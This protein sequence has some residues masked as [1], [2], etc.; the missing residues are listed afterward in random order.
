MTAH[1]P[2]MD[3]TLKV[4]RQAGP[5]TRGRFETYAAKGISTEMSFL[6]MLDVVNDR[7]ALDGKEPIAFDHDCREGICGCCGAVIN[8]KAHGS[9]KGT[10]LCQLQM[11]HYRN[12]Y[13][14][15][16]EPFRARAFPLI[17]DLAVDRTALD[18]IITTGGFISAK[19]GSAPDANAV[20]IPKR[21]ADL[22]MDA[23][24]CIG[25]GA[26]IAACPNGSAMLFLSAKI[27]HLGHL[28]QGQ[29]ER[30]TRVLKMAQKMDEL[31]FGNCTN[32][33]ECEA[34]CPKEIKFSNIAFLN[35][36]FLRAKFTINEDEKE[37]TGF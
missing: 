14:L 31:G 13:T 30:F 11:R 33:L 9:L 34:A 15:S 3:L 22:A 20:L 28:P 10:T 5:S 7:L 27:S 17:K 1:P 37:R 16:I 35:R 29:P 4:W 18:Q 6:E 21:S 23:A 8:G 24:A 32:H 2:V 19:T 25:C 26:C 36:D 12:G